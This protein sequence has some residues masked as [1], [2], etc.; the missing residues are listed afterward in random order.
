M[1]QLSLWEQREPVASCF[2]VSSL[3][4]TL[5]DQSKDFLRQITLLMGLDGDASTKMNAIEEIVDVYIG[6]RAKSRP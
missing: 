1:Q 3:L 5:E 4:I 2:R 6:E